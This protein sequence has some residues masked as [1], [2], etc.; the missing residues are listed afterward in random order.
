MTRRVQEPTLTCY[1]S[2]QFAVEGKFKS[3]DYEE[4]PAY[5]RILNEK[6]AVKLSRGIQ[7]DDRITLSFSLKVSKP[8]NGKMHIL[9]GRIRIGTTTNY[10]FVMECAI[11]D[12]EANQCKSK[13]PGSDQVVKTILM[14]GEI[15]PQI[16][17]EYFGTVTFDFLDKR[18]DIWS[19]FKTQRPDDK[20]ILIPS[21]FSYIGINEISVENVIV[22]SVEHSKKCSAMEEYQFESKRLEEGEMPKLLIERKDFPAPRRSLGNQFTF[23]VPESRFDYFNIESSEQNLWIVDVRLFQDFKSRASN[24]SVMI[25]FWN[26]NSSN[27]AFAFILGQ[28]SFDV[29]YPE[30][31]KNKSIPLNKKLNMPK[32]KGHPPMDFRFKISQSL[33]DM[34]VLL[35]FSHTGHSFSDTVSLPLPRHF[36]EIRLNTGAGR[37]YDVKMKSLREVTVMTCNYR[38]LGVEVSEEEVPFRPN[39][40][41][42]RNILCQ[43]D[44][45]DL[46]DD[47]PIPDEPEEKYIWKKGEKGELGNSAEESET[48]EGTPKKKKVEK[49]VA[50]KIDE[51]IHIENIEGFQWSIIVLTTLTVTFITA[52]LILNVL[53]SWL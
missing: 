5:L 33:T 26:R 39:C 45:V 25:N 3:V 1:K 8:E 14:V 41:R 12:K 6:G 50:G 38:N 49:L 20:T 2:S 19:R 32:L 51:D 31:G 9:P 28:I 36:D 15:K 24:N 22:S 29:I 34:T 44:A 46:E 7:M 16:T 10:S 43:K 42:K 30:N 11:S 52:I 40:F 47:A 23:P 18:V 48:S 4:P 13:Y 53:R 21:N 17:V 37:F 35:T 27:S